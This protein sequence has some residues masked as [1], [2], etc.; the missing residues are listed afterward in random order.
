MGIIDP[1]RWGL[2]T[3]IYVAQL[4]TQIQNWFLNIDLAITRHYCKANLSLPDR[5]PCQCGTGTLPV[6]LI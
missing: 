2:V 1:A 6:G 3:A 5:D 4:S